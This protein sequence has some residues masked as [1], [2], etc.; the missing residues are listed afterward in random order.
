MTDIFK[1][2]TSFEGGEISPRLSARSD[3]K[4]YQTGLDTCENWVVTPQ[5][6]LLMRE[7]T[8]YIGEA[9]SPDDVRLIGFKRANAEDYVVEISAP[10]GTDPGKLR[11]WNKEGGVDLGG[12]VYNLL[13]NGKFTQGADNVESWNA[14]KFRNGDSWFSGYTANNIVPKGFNGWA[15]IMSHEPGAAL[16]SVYGGLSQ[17]IDVPIGV[18]SLDFTYITKQLISSRASSM[19][20]TISGGLCIVKYSVEVG[21]TVGGNDLVNESYDD[22][23]DYNPS[24]DGLGTFNFTLDTTGLTEIWVT[25]KAV[26]FLPGGSGAGAFY[27]GIAIG[28]VVIN[29]PSGSVN[30]E[31]DHPWS[32]EDLQFIQTASETAKSRMVLVSR[33]QAPHELILTANTWFFQPIVF[34]DPPEEWVEGNYPGVVEIFQSRLW[35]A[36][37]PDDLARVWAS[38]VGFLD[39]FGPD[40]P[41]LIVDSDPIDVILATRGVIQWMRGMSSTLLIGTDEGEHVVTSSTGAISPL[42]IHVNPASNHGSAYIQ[43]EPIADEVMFISDDRRKLRAISYTDSRQNWTAVDL[44]F[45]SEHITFSKV[46]RIEN[47]KNPNYQI[48]LLLDDGTWVQCTYN[49]GTETLS[50]HKHQTN[51]IGGV[52]SLTVVSNSNG[53]VMWQAVKRDNG[54]YIEYVE[55]QGVYNVNLDSWVSRSSKNNPDPEDDEIIEDGGKWYAIKLEHLEG[56]EVF[57]LQ[58]GANGGFQTVTSGRV[59]IIAP[60]PTIIKEVIVGLPYIATAQ[61]LP[62]E[63]GDTNQSIQSF[64]QRRTNMTLRLVDSIIPKINGILSAERGGSSV[65]DLKEPNTTDDIEYVIMNW[66]KGSSIVITQDLPLRTEIVGVFGKTESY[67]V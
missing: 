13:A 21:S 46:R 56:E 10:I 9:S 66:D 64:M 14:T 26:P 6:S 36:S 62:V 43:A 19:H 61:L 59:E 1:S 22:D 20:N 5:G 32:A 63:T 60:D 55:A 57:I 40:D 34:I 4:R 3:S 11:V 38:K 51:A 24:G 30:F 31:T 25:I 52:K 16:S 33:T 53:S 44:T 65:M 29:D 17:R 27:G 15:E 12:E 50:W 67:K 49:R 41:E 42:D 7:G 39:N 58:D 2:Q 8:K 47:L 23:L 28:N 48:I 37:T 45:P 35:L 18:D 54:I